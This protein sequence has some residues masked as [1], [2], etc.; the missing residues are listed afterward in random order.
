MP[1]I[2]KTIR[3]PKNTNINGKIYCR[4]CMSYKSPANFYEATNHILDKNNLMSVCRECCNELYQTYF[5]IHNNLE[6][7]LDLTCRDLDVI[8]DTDALTQTKSH[9]ESLLSKGKKANAVFGYYKSKLSTTTKNNT[10]I[11]S[12]RYQDSGFNSNRL[13]TIEPL[14]E[15][16]E[17]VDQDV[18]IY[19]GKNKDN[20]EY[21]FLENEMYRLKTDFECPDYG[22][23]M[24][25]KDICCIN[26]EIERI[27]QGLEKGDVTKLITSRS[28]LMNDGNLKPVQATGADK[29]E[30]VSFGV[31]IK[32]W[33]NEDP[34]SKTMDDE[35]K[36]YIDTYMVGHLAKMEGLNNEATRL[37]DEAI[38][39]FTIDFT[40]VGKEEY[41]EE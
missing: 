34:I 20:W 17:E 41:E 35:M 18:K 36:R 12:F 32:K 26:L 13:N 28:S 40:S 16:I 22:M 25:M 37:Y 39:E 3:E 27:R 21:D 9:I 29:N 30:K 1:K 24:I 33:E 7:A 5:A 38:K 23:E 15:N 6:I 14:D 19:W 4:M 31:F 2:N 11:D 10:G 8:Y